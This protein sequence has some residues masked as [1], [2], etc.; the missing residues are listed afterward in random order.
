MT[1]GYY[2]GSLKVILIFIL[3]SVHLAVDAQELKKPVLD[4]TSAC[5]SASSNRFTFK[6]DFSGSPFDA[7]NE[8]IIQLSDAN[9]SFDNAFEMDS[10]ITGKNFTYFN[11]VGAISLPTSTYGSSY[12][13]RIKSTSPEIIGPESDSF[14]AYY[15]TSQRLV[16]NNYAPVYLCDANATTISLNDI[17]ENA[18]YNWYRG[19]SLIPGE[20]GT[21]ITVSQSGEYYAAIDYGACG[22]VVKS[23]KIN[24]QVFNS[25]NV[26]I[27]GDNVVELCGSDTYEL[28]STVDNSAYIYKWYKDGRLITGLPSYSPRY[29]TGTSDQY[30]E[31][32]VKV[33]VSNTCEVETQKVTIRERDGTNFT[34]NAVGDQNKVLLPDETIVLTA[35]HNSSNPS[36]QWYKNGIALPARN[37]IEMNA[38]EQGVYYL[39]VTDNSSS[40]SV[41]KKSPEYKIIK[42]VK[43]IPI[44]GATNYTECESENTKIVVQSVKGESAD[45]EQYSLT[46]EQIAKLRL[47][48]FKD[49]NLISGLGME[50]VIPSHQENGE[51]FAGASISNLRG[52]SEKIHINLLPSNLGVEQS[53]EF[54]CPGSEVLLTTTIVPDFEYKWS[55]GETVINATDASSISVGDTGTYTLQVTGSGGC[56]KTFNIEVKEFNADAVKV[57]PSTIAVLGGDDKVLVT[58]SGAESY[59]WYNSEGGLLSTSESFEATELGTYTLNAKLGICN[60]VKKIQVVEDDGSVII[61]NIVTPFNGDGVNDT[62]Q[63]PNKYAFQENVNIVIYNSRGKEVLNTT[64]YQN[65]WPKDDNV[66]GGM[67]FYFKVIRGET[68]VKAGTLS[69]LK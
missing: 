62:W 23:N 61:P 36:Y 12:K 18:E 66:R 16:L 5:G 50:R 49:N 58:A 1:R 48:W 56:S 9:G 10:R 45:G 30:G 47:E 17:G 54:L 25:S 44:L 43:L 7:A 4:F 55:K 64:D 3:L 53:A 69:I 20:R 8:F 6:F 60:V 2:I 24:A 29:T 68:L 41:V 28:V 63:I 34:I 13:I 57:S 32:Y 39:E 38:I 27:Q 14:E 51:Y 35:T 33:Q 11:I 22:D 65:D 37:Q 59:E 21:S 46:S 31:Y 40:C 19:G 42:P 67:L 52:S 15:I 26:R